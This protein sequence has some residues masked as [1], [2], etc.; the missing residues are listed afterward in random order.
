MGLPGLSASPRGLG[1]S[2]RSL[3]CGGIALRLFPLEP[4]IPLSD[5]P[6]QPA[7]HLW[8]WQTSTDAQALT[9]GEKHICRKVYRIG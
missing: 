8:E 7:M 6:A 3:L 1:A 9:M 2:R 5:L 4:G